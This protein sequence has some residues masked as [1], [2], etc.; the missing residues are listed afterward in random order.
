MIK[1]DQA[2]VWVITAHRM[3]R[4]RL[5]GTLGGWA[6]RVAAL[7]PDQVRDDAFWSTRPAGPA[8]VVL[9]VDGPVEHGLDVIRQ[10]RKARM[11]APIV[12]LTP[13]F[14]RDFGAK[15]L[16]QGVRYYFSHDYCEEEFL[17]VARS[18]LGV[19]A[20]GAGDPPGAECQQKG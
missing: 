7:D 5:L 17:A 14:S 18:L 11:Q 8:L 4:K 15:I 3:L 6:A 2:S 12:V 10:L 1:T 9:D 13:E 16:S 19:T 20:N